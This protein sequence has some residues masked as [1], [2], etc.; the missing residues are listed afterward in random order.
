MP[1][2]L[3]ILGNPENRRVGFALRAAESLGWREVRVVS[4]LAF[5][6]NSAALTNEL[7]PDGW[8]RIESPGENFEVEKALLRLGARAAEGEDFDRLTAGAVDALPFRRGEILPMYQW[9]IGWKITLLLVGACLG[10]VADCRVMNHPWEITV[11]FDKARCHEVLAVAGVPQPA[12]LGLPTSYE[13]LRELMRVTGCGRV[14]LKPCHSSSASGVVALE[15]GRG[16]VQA[17]SSVEMADG[18]LFNSL[19]VRRYRDGREVARLVDAVCRQR[20]LAERWFP[21]A[22]HDGQR[23]DLRVLVIGG[24][25]AHTVMRQSGGPIT[26]LHLG[27]R[28]GDLDGLRRRVGDA[29][30]QDALAVAERAAGAF[31][32]S[33]YVAVDLLVAPGFR[34]FAVAEVN[35]FGDLLPNLLHEGRDT[36]TAEFARLLETR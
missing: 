23:F 13:H 28:R 25:A 14:F 12:L 17:F 9:Y 36:Y 10:K 5:L 35:A 1:P 11:M 30:W 20:S 18:W 26:N 6:R 4:W 8:L 22:G 15:L 21:K 33:L 27:N 29:A 24:R 31:P 19:S 7:R 3:V 2:P 16:G 32:H 34:R